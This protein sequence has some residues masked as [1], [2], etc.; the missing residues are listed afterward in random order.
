MIDTCYI[1]LAVAT[2]DT[3]PS[4]GGTVPPMSHLAAI[5]ML[6]AERGADDGWRFE[7]KRHAIEAGD[8]EDLLLAWA[9]HALPRHGVLLG[10]QL[11][12]RIMPVLIDASSTGDPGIAR[13]FLDRL[14]KL[15]TLPSIELAV[16]HGGAGAAPFDDVAARCGIHICPLSADARESAWAF[17]DTGRLQRHV[18]AEAVALWQLCLADSA[19]MQTPTRAATAA[20]LETRCK[21]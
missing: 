8:G 2:V 12:E 13:T 3:P 10:W 1:T 4:T 21:R 14:L 11:A 7:L 20:W 6:I 16:P 15:V 19:E 17:G 5:A 9:T 18:E